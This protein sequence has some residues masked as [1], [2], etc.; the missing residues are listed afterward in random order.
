MV[1]VTI[2][3]STF[4]FTRLIVEVDRLAG[5]GLL[6]DVVAQIGESEYEPRNCT[7]QRFLTPSEFCAG[8]QNADFVICHAGYGTLE[9]GLR[10][11]KKMIAVPRRIQHKEAP[12][13]H[14]IEIA[15]LL[16]ANNRILL[17]HD[18]DELAACVQAVPTWI[19][20]FAS[21]RTGNPIV[22]RIRQFIKQEMPA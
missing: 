8:M 22:D 17:A 11:H 18:M 12:D 10:L 1:F 20:S 2:G 9:E 14:Q 15:H 5:T 21:P 16:E 3:S 13:D 19:P 7:W 6:S 4:G